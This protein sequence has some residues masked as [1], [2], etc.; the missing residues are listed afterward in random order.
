MELY[1]E[2]ETRH[3]VST[4]SVSDAFRTFFDLRAADGYLAIITFLSSHPFVDAALGRLREQ[5]ASR[6][7]IPVLL[8]SGPRYLHY[9]EQ[10]YKGGPPKGLFLILTSEPA[11]DIVIPG[12]G[13]TFGQLQLA[14]AMG[15]FESFE[16][17][18][19][20]VVRIHLTQ[21][22]EQSLAE[23]EQVIQQA[24]VNTRDSGR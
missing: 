4:L 8:S 14:L 3:Q 13:Y 11:E 20:L 17:R 5:L 19:K 21:G 6:L 16:S 22:L 15:D 2:G 9:F 1:A 7:G 24:L 12:A 10:V 18:Q 23:L